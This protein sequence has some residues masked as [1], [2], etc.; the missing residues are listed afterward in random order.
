MSTGGYWL[1]DYGRDR[2]SLKWGIRTASFL[3]FF[4]AWEWVGRSGR[5][6]AIVPATTTLETLWEDLGVLWAASLGTLRTAAAGYILAILVGIPVGSFVGL[7]RR[8]RI[9]ID[10]LISVG[11]VAPMTM[12]I[13]VIGI[14]V[15]LGFRG[16][17]FLVFMF[18]VFVI[19]IN[20]ALGI[21]E[22]SPSLH[23]TARAFGVR[24]SAMYRK[25]IFPNALPNILTGVRLGAG[26]AI[27]GAIIADLLLQVENLGKYLIEAG[28]RFDMAAL[29]AGTF[30]TVIL[31]S[32]VMLLARYLERRSLRWLGV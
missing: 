19:A 22:L 2:T 15:G 31:A 25:V 16:K 8:A 28:S 17:V 7:S 12:L 14:Y 3:L 29:L 21:A 13:P 30:F 11:V 4:L 23:E 27:Q 5:F 26:R 1:W 32:S 10:P 20:T 24:G 18:S 9:T 6:F